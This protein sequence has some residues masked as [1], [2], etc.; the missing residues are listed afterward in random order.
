VV[1]IDGKALRRSFDKGLGQGAIPMVSA[2]ALANRL[3]LGQQKVDEMSNEIIA[4]PKLLSLLN[5]KGCLVTIDAMGCQ[6][7]IAQ[8]IVEHG[9][10]YLL[11]LKKS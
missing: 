6:T 8:R 7:E 9:A 4:I 11:A 5:L 3:V 10:D 2:W 1:A